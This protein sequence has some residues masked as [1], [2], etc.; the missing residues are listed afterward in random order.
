MEKKVKIPEFKT[1]EEMARFWDSHDITDF[2]DQLT[3]VKEPIFQKMKSRIISFKLDSEQ[4]EKL[5]KIADQKKL[6]TVSLVNQ[7][8]TKQ[9]ED[10]SNQH[11]R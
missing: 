5:K 2:E 11:L 9:I 10:E 7:W 3:E 8:V 4:Y 1:I 6:N